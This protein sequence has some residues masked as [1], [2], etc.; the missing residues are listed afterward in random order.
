M[1]ECRS[2]VRDSQKST[3]IFMVIQAFYETFIFKRHVRPGPLLNKSRPC[4][5]DRIYYS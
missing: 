4:E 5:E 3:T 2:F 1:N